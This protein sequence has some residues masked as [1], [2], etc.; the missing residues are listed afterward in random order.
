MTMYLSQGLQSGPRSDAKSESNRNI[1][2][3]ILQVKIEL[4]DTQM[5]Q[6]IRTMKD[7][8]IVILV[9]MLNFQR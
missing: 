3:N 1:P 8:I 5:P 2:R 6:F 7:C 4:Q 9:V